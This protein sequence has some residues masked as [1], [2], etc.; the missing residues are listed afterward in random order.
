MK[1]KIIY[2]VILAIT[3]Q[4]F[5]AQ[6]VLQALDAPSSMQLPDG[7]TLEVQPIRYLASVYDNNYYPMNV[8]DLSSQPP[9][10]QLGSQNANATTDPLLNYQGRIGAYNVSGGSFSLKIQEAFD[11]RIYHVPITF[12]N[13]L[14]N[15]YSFMTFDYGNN[16]IISEAIIPA[17]YI[18]NANTDKKVYLQLYWGDELRLLTTDNK[19]IE[20]NAFIC[21]EEPIELV[22]LD[23]NRGI[24]QDGKGILLTTFNIS[25]TTS[26]GV[27]SKPLELRL[28]PAIPDRYADQKTSSY[29]GTWAADEYE[30][31][32]FYM[33]ITGPDGKTWLSNDLGAGYSQL[34]SYYF[35]PLY[36]SGSTHYSTGLPI[37][38]PTIYEIKRD[39]RG[40]G[41][42]FQWQRIADG[43]E[44]KF[45]TSQ[46]DTKSK[47]TTI[48]TIASNSWV[49]AGTNKVIESEYKRWWISPE[50]LHVGPH[51]LWKSGGSNNPCP[52]GYH[53][54]TGNELN[55]LTAIIV[56]NDPQIALSF[57]TNSKIW[58]DKE[59]RFSTLYD[60]C[61]NVDGACEEDAKGSRGSIYATSSFGPW[62]DNVYGLIFTP[63]VYLPPKFLVTDRSP[64]LDKSYIRC[65]KD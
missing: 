33:P 31:D 1:N 55:D 28:L 38:D 23:M 62:R 47:Y 6:V 63:R 24:G 25:F 10:A 32:M 16:K 40:R 57:I 22:Q 18:K 29:A 2:L 15:D 13:E 65:R 9:T 54:P 35:N 48:S 53:V 64:V 30:H 49:D 12:I 8:L 11:R 42:L 3:L 56:G 21:A 20:V 59:F 60:V 14:Q 26:K 52:L 43:H 46:H 4:F 7:W 41:S 39:F 27:M 58:D 36:R 44:L 34:M 61:V 5:K 37:S 19:R 17:M 45:H 51:D 50:T